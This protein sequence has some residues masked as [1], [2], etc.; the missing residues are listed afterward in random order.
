MVDS[1]AIRKVHVIFDHPSNNSS[2]HFVQSSKKI[3]VSYFLM[4]PSMKF[5]N[6]YC[7]Y[8]FK[9]LALKFFERLH[10]E[11]DKPKPICSPV[12]QSW[13][14]KDKCADQLG[15]NCTADQHLCF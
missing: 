5:Q 12:F 9:T 2:V 14:H 10:G 13:G 8:S 3:W 11:T 1:K 4:N 6:I 15:C 7:G